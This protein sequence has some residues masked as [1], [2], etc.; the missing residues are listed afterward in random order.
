VSLTQEEA[1]IHLVQE[2][3]NL[4]VFQMV[5]GCLLAA[6]RELHTMKTFPSEIPSKFHV[7]LQQ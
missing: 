1:V 6:Y 5:Q 4:I 7:L 3:S 2:I